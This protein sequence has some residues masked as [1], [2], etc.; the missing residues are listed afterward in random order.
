MAL[1]EEFS[2]IATHYPID[3]NAIPTV[4][5]GMFC[6]LLSTGYADL[7]DGVASRAV[8]GVFGDSTT[9]SSSTELATTFSD[10]VVINANGAT[11][12]TQNRV[13]DP[14]GDES[15]ASGRITV[16]NGGGQFH[17]DIFETLDGAVPT[18]YLPGDPLYVSSNGKITSNTTSPQAATCVVAARA[19]P[20]GVP[21][22][23]TTDGSLSLGSFLTFRLDV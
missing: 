10:Q 11:L 14:S 1:I 3:P 15:S 18:N 16:Y 9:L 6:K 7:H 8:M 20:S 23:D 4:R 5:E 22:T 17:T 19:Y 13:S 21:G 2:V 12:F